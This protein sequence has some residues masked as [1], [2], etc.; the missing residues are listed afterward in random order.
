MTSTQDRVTA[1]RLVFLV[2]LV[3]MLAGGAAAQHKSSTPSAPHVSAPSH[4]SAPAARPQ[5]SHPSNANHAGPTG[6]RPNNMGGARPG[7]G[8]AAN[9]PGMGNRPGVGNRP[10]TMGNRNGNFSRP[11]NGTLGR[12]GTSRPGMGGRAG[13]NGRTTGNLGRAGSRP[14][15]GRQVSLRG[16]GTASL[17][18][19]GQIRSINRNG[20]QIS[21]G[22]NG[23]R[24]IESMHNGA[25]VVSTGRHSGYV[26]RAYVTRGGRTYVSR[27]VVVNH[28]TYT[29]VYRSYSYHGYCCYYG[30]HPAFYY[31]PVYYGWAYNPWPAPVYYGWGWGGAPWYGYYGGYFAPYPTYPSAAFWLTDYLIAA[32]LQAA[33]AARAQAAAGAAGGGDNGGGNGGDNTADNGGG[34]GQGDQQAQGNGGNDSGSNSQQVTLSPEVKQ[35]IA[36]EVKAQIAAEQA[37]ANQGSSNQGSSNQSSP[38]QG[39][40]DQGQ[41]SQSSNDEVP[42]ALDPIRRTFVV[43]SDMT[44]NVDGQEC[45]LT[46]G[47]VITRMS[48]E[49]DQDHNVTVT[50]AASRKSECGIGKQ[51]LVSVDDLQEMYNHFQEQIDNGMKDLAAKQGSNGLPKAPDTNT[52][53]SDVPPPPPDNSAAKALED[54]Q[55]AADQTEAQ[56][57]KEAF[58]QGS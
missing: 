20:M 42:P 41:A 44:L 24:H 23:S 34:N 55:Q 45:Q 53:P 46:Q 5:A 3:F 54:Q 21:H 11:G 6:G 51:A 7:A 58:S 39:S 13:M 19:N 10:G 18:P 27:T 16:G 56:V 47:D 9:R 50:V 52:T 36:D 32:N 33:Y 1:L 14:L 22:L 48:D 37:S 30:Y 4:A 40:S 28:V 38:N 29:S 8:N 35:A 12:N 25:R 43:A 2:L 15:P 17:R 31:H 57:V 49:P 26:Q